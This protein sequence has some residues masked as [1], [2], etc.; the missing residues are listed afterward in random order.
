[1]DWIEL[2]AMANIRQESMS[3]SQIFI[4]TTGRIL[5]T[6]PSSTEQEKIEMYQEG[7]KK[8]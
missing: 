6:I 7:V 1:M 4:N 2:A 3:K 5:L 8:S